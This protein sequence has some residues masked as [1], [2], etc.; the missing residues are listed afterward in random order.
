MT[1]NRDMAAAPR[2]KNVR[3]LLVHPKDNKVFLTSWLEPTKH[4]PKGRWNGWSE[5]VEA[6]AW[7]HIPVFQD[8]SH[9]PAVA[10]DHLPILDDVVSGA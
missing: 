3:L 10:S 6:K 5:G 7:M 8:G 1:W 4:T 2:D 9:V